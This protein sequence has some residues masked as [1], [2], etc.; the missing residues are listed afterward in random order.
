MPRSSRTFLA[1]VFLFVLATSARADAGATIPTYRLKVGQILNYHAESSTKYGERGFGSSTDWRGWVVR[2]NPDGGWRVVLRSRSKET[3]TNAGKTQDDGPASLILVYADLRPDGQFS[4]NDSLSTQISLANLFPQLP[5]DAAELSNGWQGTLPLQNGH[6]E[7]HRADPPAADPSA[8]VFES[9]HHSQMNKVY[10]STGGARLT[11]D[12]ERGLITRSENRHTQDYGVH[13]KGSG[14]TELIAIEEQPIEKAATFADEADR[15]F[16]LARRRDEMLDEATRDP[17]RTE[18]LLAQVKAT[19]VEARDTFRLPDFLDQL[20]ALLKKHD[21]LSTH[22]HREA[23]DRAKLMG[24]DVADWQTTDLDGKPHALKDF[25]GKVVI[26]DFWNRGCGWC[27]Q[28]MPQI[29]QL[30]DDFQ[31][32]PVAILGMN[33]DPDEKDARLVLDVMSLNYPTLKAQEI[34]ETY[35]VNAYPTLLILDKAGKIADV[36]IGYSPHLRD[37]V[38]ASIKALLARE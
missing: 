25:R 6:T 24:M 7:Y 23:K 8:F 38:A 35:Q 15:F 12:R 16:D 34:A 21:R 29:K 33:T 1:F 17:L 19:L 14:T 4:P 13:S 32:Q 27:I 30:A 5:R 31:G 11:F 37:R 2:Q 22:L 26:L 10:L 28:A 3:T 36:H 9:E 20:D 18:A